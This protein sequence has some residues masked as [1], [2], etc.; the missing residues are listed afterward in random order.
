MTLPLW[1]Q[2]QKSLDD[3]E[4]IEQAIERIVAEHNAEPE[5]HLGTGESLSEHKHTTVLDHPAGSVLAD[6]F[7][8]D[9]HF[10]YFTNWRDDIQRNRNLGSLFR[11]GFCK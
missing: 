10:F 11:M 2:L 5:A 4:T 1:G 9:E 7:S 6:K 8:D 3:T